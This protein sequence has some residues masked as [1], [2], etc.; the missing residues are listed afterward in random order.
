MGLG[1]SFAQGEGPK[2]REAR[3]RRGRRVNALAVPDMDKLRYV[4]D[5]VT[6]DPQGA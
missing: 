3:A 5:A 2:L 4:F 1:L 6:S